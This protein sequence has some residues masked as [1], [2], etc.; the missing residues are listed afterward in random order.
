M[1][2]INNNIGLLLENELI[3]NE[4][5]EFDIDING[6]IKNTNRIN[7]RNIQTIIYMISPLININAYITILSYSYDITGKLKTSFSKCKQIIINNCL[8]ELKKFENIISKYMIGKQLNNRILNMIKVLYIIDCKTSYE[9]KPELKELI[10]LI[11]Y[12]IKIKLL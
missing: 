9:Y 5:C 10:K 11:Y 2:N 12:I 4:I 1:D 6:L 8:L 7:S 3:K